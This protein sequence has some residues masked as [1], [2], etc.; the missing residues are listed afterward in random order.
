MIRIVKHDK[1]S[2]V[3]IACDKCRLIKQS[4]FAFI[5]LEGWEHNGK[6]H[7]CPK[8]RGANKGTA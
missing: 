2:F 3:V 7:L 6:E 1:K 8:C 4:I 5:H